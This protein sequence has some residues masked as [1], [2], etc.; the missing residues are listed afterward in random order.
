[1]DNLLQGHETFQYLFQ[2]KHKFKESKNNNNNDIPWTVI[3]VFVAIATAAVCVWIANTNN[4]IN[5]VSFE[6]CC[7]PPSSTTTVTAIAAAV[8]FNVRQSF[9]C[10]SPFVLT[11][12][13]IASAKNANV[14]CCQLVSFVFVD[15]VGVWA[16]S[17]KSIDSQYGR[18]MLALIHFD[19]SFSLSS[20]RVH[21]RSHKH[22]HRTPSFQFAKIKKNQSD[23]EQCYRFVFWALYHRCNEATG[24]RPFMFFN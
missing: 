16:H 8:S 10:V 12:T 13:R 24:E 1:M 7:H 22:T 23:D 2:W 3:V 11:W 21:P 9:A 14:P 17:A 18:P 15:A 5:F 4:L 6:I 19:I 20:S